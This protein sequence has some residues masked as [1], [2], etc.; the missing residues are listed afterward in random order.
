M[1]TLLEVAWFTIKIEPET[2]FNNMNDSKQHQNTIITHQHN[3]N[4]SETMQNNILGLMGQRS[5][6]FRYASPVPSH[7]LD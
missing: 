3:H 2:T 5:I 4:T 1:H 7:G 6:R